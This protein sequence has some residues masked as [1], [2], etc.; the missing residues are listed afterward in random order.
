MGSVPELQRF[1]GE[2][3]GNPLQDSCLENPMDRGA[4]SQ[5]VRQD[6][7]TEHT[8]NIERCLF[9]FL[10]W[11]IIYFSHNL[12]EQSLYTVL[13]HC[14]ICLPSLELWL[15]NKEKCKRLYF[16]LFFFLVR[17]TAQTL[18][19]THR[20]EQTLVSILWLLLHVFSRAYDFCLENSRSGF[21]WALS[22][23]ISETTAHNIDLFP[24]NEAH[25]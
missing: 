22:R 13:N 9:F 7:T 12:W 8:H 11:N 20:F 25:N 17:N 21:L 18:P 19:Q 10:I 2:G 23:W 15:S 24:V 6:W 16:G 1:P 5:R 3:N 14:E 4:W